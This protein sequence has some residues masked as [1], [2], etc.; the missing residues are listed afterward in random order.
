METKRRSAWKL[1]QTQCSFSFSERM[2]VEYGMVKLGDQE[3]YFSITADTQTRHP[4]GGVWH[5]CSGG[6]LHDEIKEH[7]PELAHLITWHL[8]SQGGVPMHY[9]ANGR[10]WLEKV[11]GVSEWKDGPVEPDPLEAF[12]STV[13]LGALGPTDVPPIALEDYQDWAEKRLPGL[14]TRFLEAMEKAGV[15]LIQEGASEGNSGVQG[16]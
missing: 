10:Y 13:C 15:A 4:R 3:P 14:R 11:F 12:S 16:T 2:R 6:C 8:V 1:I 9:L 7:F 5:E